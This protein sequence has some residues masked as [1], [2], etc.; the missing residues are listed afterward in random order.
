MLARSPPNSEGGR[1]EKEVKAKEFQFRDAR[2]ETFVEKMQENEIVCLSTKEP[3]H[4]F[5]NMGDPL[6]MLLRIQ[7]C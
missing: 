1:E 5:L 4:S 3:V 7:L 2:K 6:F